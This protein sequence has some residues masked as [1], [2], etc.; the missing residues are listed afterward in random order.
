MSS[1]I[2]L[3]P[4]NICLKTSFKISS[5]YK[6]LYLIMKAKKPSK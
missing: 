1:A 2:G 5:F 3:L 6:F 4:E